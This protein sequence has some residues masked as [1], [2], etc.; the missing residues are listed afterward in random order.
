M[1]QVLSILLIFQFIFLA[2]ASSYRSIDPRKVVYNN[3]QNVNGLTFSY[4]Y[5]VLRE[6][7]N[8]KYA[9]NELKKG[10]HVVAIKISNRSNR[11][12]Q[13]GKSLSIINNSSGIKILLIDPKEASKTL[14]QPVAIYLLYCLMTPLPIRGSKGYTRDDVT[15]LGYI[16]GPGL[17]A[18]NML[19]ASK[20]NMRFREELLQY[21]LTEK[22]IAPGEEVYG[23]VEMIYTGYE[24][25]RI[26]LDP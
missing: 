26:D 2:C 22:L 1:S 5:N 8:T 16:I 24:P 3:S 15:T 23:L 25:L 12:V 6:Q 14:K 10:M 7:G 19:I 17:A 9:K 11:P 18:S 20:S 13:L 21:N 4:H